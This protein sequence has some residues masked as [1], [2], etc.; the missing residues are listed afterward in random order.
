MR[1]LLLFSVFVLLL[2][3][4]S[5]PEQPGPNVSN[6]TPP[7]V[8]VQ[9]CTDSDGG[10]DLSIKGIVRAGGVYEDRCE[11]ASV[12]E[13]YCSGR[14]MNSSIVPCAE[15]F[16]CDGGA[17]IQPPPTNMTEPEPVCLDTD[18]GNDEWTAG[19]VVFGGN[20]FR[21]VCQ[22]AFD[23]LEYY[24]ENETAQQRTLNCGTGNKCENG[25]CIELGRTCS[26]SDSQN[27]SASGTTIQYGGGV[28]I[29][30]QMDRC[31][32]DVNKIE[33]SCESGFMANRTYSCASHTYCY[34]GACV[35]IC[36]DQDGG[37]DAETASSVIT[38]EGTFGDYCKSDLEL[39]EYSC[40]GD[41]MRSAELVCDGFCSDGRCY[42]YSEL[43][44]R[45]SS[46]GLYV[47]LLA[48]DVVVMQD[49]DTC[50]DYQTARDY[51][52]VGEEVNYDNTRC[53][54]DEVCEEGEC[55]RITGEGCHDY[56][57]DAPEGDIHVASYAVETT[58]DS[59]RRVRE[60][61]CFTDIIVNEY[62]CDEEDI[63]LDSVTCPE[64]EKCV[65]GA[66]KYPY[67]CTDSDGGESL[68]PGQASLSEG[69]TI[70]RTERDACRDDTHVHETICTDDD[71]IGYVV[72]AC[73]TGTVC[74]PSDGS[75]K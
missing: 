62:S 71:H 18:G 42:D 17:C 22:G 6:Q 55:E 70:V 36:T 61:E 21:D 45:E 26:D 30:T 75:C 72:L 35:P 1:L 65:D 57:L 59:I 23:L 16:M 24:C 47:R 20:T 5:Q 52:C 28:V 64:E 46:G 38:K 4:I 60:D 2:G 67:T 63:V 27:D 44:C 68:Q 39:V 41:L 33:F 31:L 58:N 74:D 3:C 69:A 54:D 15:G 32:D 48:D 34:N 8:P 25:A 53:E 37:A 40:S 11:G 50:I 12:L 66:C 49:N 14:S 43:E 10:I 29:S 51:F 73:P 7:P 9:T 56:D 13:Y 19:S